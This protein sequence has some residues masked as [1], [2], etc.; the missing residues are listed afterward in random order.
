[1]RLRIG[2]W[3]FSPTLWPTL[4]ALFFFVLTFWLGNWQS[5]RA[6]SKRALQA[7]YDMALTPPPLHMGIAALALEDVLYHR[8]EVE[9][10]F[11]PANTILLDNRVYNGA[12][13]YHVLTPLK[14]AGSSLSVLV[15]RGWIA[16][17]PLRANPPVPVT[18]VGWGQAGR[19]RDRPAQ[20]IF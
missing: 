4:A 14:I 10:E 8:V 18:P 1:M 11:D 3:R 13:G 9:G 6:Q 16:P 2:A 7:R 19:H 20:P 15:N 12:A 17:G 5:E